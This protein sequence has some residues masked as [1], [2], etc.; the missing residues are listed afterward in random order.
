MTTNAEP[1]EAVERCRFL[2]ACLLALFVL[3]PRP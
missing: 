1:L 2:L 3:C